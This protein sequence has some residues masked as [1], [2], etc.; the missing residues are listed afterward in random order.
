MSRK[1]HTTSQFVIIAKT[2]H[3]NRYDYSK[4]VYAGAHKKLIIT[5]P[6]HG[7]FEQIANSHLNGRGCKQCT[8]EKRRTKHAI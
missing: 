2:I 8:V 1:M 3:G 4:T 7:D 6:V 5:C